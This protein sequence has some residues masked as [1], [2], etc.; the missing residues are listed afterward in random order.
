MKS[1]HKWST[2]T[3]IASSIQPLMTAVVTMVLRI[4]TIF[5]LLSTLSTFVFSPPFHV[6]KKVNK[7]Y[8]ERI[9]QPVSNNVLLQNTPEQTLLP[10]PQIKAQNSPCLQTS[11]F[12]GRW[13]MKIVFFY[14]KEI[15]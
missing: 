5:L 3:E 7:F 1:P 2:T 8:N 4:L 11:R 13:S 15:F 12:K 10:S 14:R 6:T 9:T